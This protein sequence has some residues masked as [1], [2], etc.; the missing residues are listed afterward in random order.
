M[1]GRFVTP[2]NPDQI[3]AYFGAEPP[4]VEL[5]QS[6][7]TAPTNDIYAIVEGPDGVRRVE[8]FHW[9]L[10]PSWAKDT[11][12]GSKMINARCETLIEKPVFKSLFKAKRCIVPMEG[13]YEWQAGVAG[14][15]VTAKGKPAKQPF[16][17]HRLDGQPLAVAGLW[18][19]WR[20]KDAGPDAPWLHSCTVITTSANA[21]MEPIHDRM[22]VIL[23]ESAWDAWLDRE[24]NDLVDLNGLLVPAPDTLLTMHPV[25]TDVNKVSNKG[26]ELI[27][28]VD[29]TAPADGT[30]GI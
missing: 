7:N 17:V 14:G 19:A 12:I 20:D 28:P 29:P 3:A 15:P 11:K 9:G 5:Q 16:F 13:F 21:T 22:P 10:V 6:F 18:A 2:T 4:E 25:S 23:P 30:L 24:N 27:E 1:C 26:P 8:V